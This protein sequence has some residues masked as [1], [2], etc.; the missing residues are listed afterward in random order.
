MKVSAVKTKKIIPQKDTDLYAILDEFLPKLH[1]RT[2]LAVTSKIVSIC[3]GN[4]VQSSS[5]TKDELMEQEA[6]YILPAEIDP[7]R[8]FNLTIKDNILI[9]AAG[10]D[11]SNAQG[12]YVLWPKD[13]QKTADQIRQYLK[14]RFS[15]KHVGVIITDSRTN[16]LRWGTTGVALAWSGFK[17]LQ[18]YIGTEDLFGKKLEVSI[19]NVVDVLAAAAVLLM[20]E[21]AEQ[22]PL[23]IVEEIPFVTF[24]DRDPSKEELAMLH[25]GLKDPMYAPLFKSAAWRKGKKFSKKG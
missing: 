17:P 12:Y 14:K 21:G 11:E 18:N 1:E 6:E 10:I 25:V 2:V 5:I 7:T 9:P 8:R 13:S 15:L 22:T 19:S 20:G 4:V 16:P 23:A 24:I 3:E